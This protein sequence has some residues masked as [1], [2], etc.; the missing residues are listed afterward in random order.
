M[1]RQGKVL[2]R[3]E[4][5][6]AQM[7]KLN[8]KGKRRDGMSPIAKHLLAFEQPQVGLEPFRAL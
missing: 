5:A 4:T 1:T 7:R 6:L 3:R 2:R 8:S